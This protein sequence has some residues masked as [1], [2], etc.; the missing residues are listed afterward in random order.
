MGWSFHSEKVL[1]KICL[2]TFA[3][4]FLKIYLLLYV[5]TL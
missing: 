4:F 5:S 2:D 1:A 3:V